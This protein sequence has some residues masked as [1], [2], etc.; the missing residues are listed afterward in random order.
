MK[1]KTAKKCFNKDGTPKYCK[2]M[3]FSNV[4]VLCNEKYLYC[5]V[6][7]HIECPIFD[8]DEDKNRNEKF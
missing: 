6:A 1:N 5:H 7:N 2:H 4:G 3:F 8:E